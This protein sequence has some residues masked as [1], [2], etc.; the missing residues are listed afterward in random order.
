MD[1][2]DP[3]WALNHY[4]YLDNGRKSNFPLIMSRYAGIGSHRYPIG[5]S[6]DTTISWKTLE[7]MPYFT[8]TAS[9]VGYTWWGHDIGGHHLGI[10]DDELYLRFLQFGV[11]NPI[12]RMH[13]TDSQIITKEPWMYENGIGELARKMLILRHRMIP[14]LYHCNYLTHAHGRALCEPLYYSYPNAPESYQFKNQYLFGQCMIVAPITRPSTEKGLSQLEVWLPQGVW[15]DFFTGDVYRIGEG[16]KRFIAT[17]PLDSIPVFVQAGSV[18]PLSCDG[19]NHFDNPRVLE[20]QIYNGNGVCEL[21]E[22]SEN[23]SALTKFFLEET[24]GAQTVTVRVEGDS[25]VIPTNRTLKL[26]FPNIVIHH[27]ADQA[28]NLHRADAEVTALKN[29]AP[30]NV[31]VQAYAKVCVTINDFDP[32]AVYTV[33]VSYPPSPCLRRRHEP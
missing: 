10:K 1:G 24:D 5:F 4:H 22:D 6:G 8:A 29:G 32:E 14:F 18:I 30:C 23:G 31:T 3:L 28:L 33:R 7:L 26:T 21:Y 13:C 16:G 27:P 9:N 12:N 25:S 2:L 15:T 11:F 17:R 19:G 20:A